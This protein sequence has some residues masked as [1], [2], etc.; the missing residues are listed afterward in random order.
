MSVYSPIRFARKAVRVQLADPATGI[1]PALAIACANYGLAPWAFDFSAASLNFFE[2]NID[3]GKTE[4]SSIPEP[5][6]LTLYGGPAVP[7]PDRE[8]VFGARFSGRVFLTV[9]MYI[10][11]LG[12]KVQTFEDWADAAED[13][14][15][16]VMNDPSNQN[17]MNA[18]TGAGGKAYAM[19]LDAK[20]QPCV[21][22]GENW[23]VP[24]RFALT[25]GVIIT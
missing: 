12:E 1:N 8:R 23:I 18:G 20:R 13:A 22:D 25:F 19:D 10:G 5:N 7:F 9:D 2:A 4:E 11:V 21:Y 3:Y 24:T 16:A 6:L 17:G 14:M 15:F